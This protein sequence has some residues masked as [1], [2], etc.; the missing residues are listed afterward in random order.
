MTSAVFVA[1]QDIESPTVTATTSITTPALTLGETQVLTPTDVGHESVV[2]VTY[3]ND[4]QATYRPNVQSK[5]CHLNSEQQVL[6]CQVS[7]DSISR[8]A[9]QMVIN[10]GV[11]FTGSY[12]TDSTC[13]TVAE[14]NGT[15]L[16]LGLVH[17]YVEDNQ[18]MVKV[19]FSETP[20]YTS[21]AIKI[22]IVFN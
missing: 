15:D 21:I 20:S 22:N 6:S 5:Y 16:L 11:K 13:T 8:P 3:D 17:I 12:P 7:N 9:K 19:V 14:I 1:T 18:L 2:V 10:T 4:N